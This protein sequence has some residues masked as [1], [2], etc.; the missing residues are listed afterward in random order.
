MTIAHSRLKTILGQRRMNVPELERR[1]RRR[2][3]KVNIKS[4]YRLSDEHAQIERLDLKLAAAI[5][6]E[7]GVSLGELITF[8]HPQETL[9]QLSTDKQKRLDFLMKRSNEGRL[10]PSERKQLHALVTEAEEITLA[11]ARFL[12]CHRKQLQPLPPWK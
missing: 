6:E 3:I 8:A 1:I 5:C 2:G 10:R 7:C 12:A 9:R 11:I 4:L